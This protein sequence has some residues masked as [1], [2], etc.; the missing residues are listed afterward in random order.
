M[1]WQSILSEIISQQVVVVVGVENAKSSKGNAR[2]AA[3]DDDNGSIVF[4]PGA[5]HSDLLFVPM[6]YAEQ[7][8]DPAKIILKQ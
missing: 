2:F 7:G 5:A 6:K 3:Y 4:S 8:V 1:A